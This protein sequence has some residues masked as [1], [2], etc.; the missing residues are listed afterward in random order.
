MGEGVTAYL[1]AVL[2]PETF[3]FCK[4][5]SF[6]S[7]LLSWKVIQTLVIAFLL[8]AGWVVAFRRRGAVFF[9]MSVF[10]IGLIPYSQIVHFYP[11]WAEHYLYIPS[12]GLAMLL[13][14]L[15]AGLP[16][17]LPA[18]VLVALMAG[19]LAFFGFLC[20]RTWQRN[21]LYRDTVG[22][23]KRL[24]QSDS[25]YAYYGYQNLARLLI[26]NGDWA[27]AVVPLKAALAMEPRS[28]VTNNLMGLY[29]LQ[30]K[31]SREAVAYFENAYRAS[32]DLK[33]LTNAG[34][35]FIRMKAYAEAIEIF[36]S[37]Q[38][39]APQQ[40][41]VYTNLI[42]ACELS[43]DAEKAR[44]WGEAGF[45]ALREKDKEAV[46]LLMALA[47]LSYRQGWAEL[48]REK[49]GLILNRYPDSFWYG[50]LARL[51]A[52]K[53]TPDDFLEKVRINYP[54]FESAGKVSVMAAYVIGGEAALA[55][56][57]YEANK[58]VLEEQA[59]G[60]PLIDQE[61]RKAR[62]FISGKAAI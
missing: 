14:S 15:I 58:R 30:M 3:K 43:G 45:Q 39:S 40:L 4:S 1:Q 12:M 13:G 49:V 53:M 35:A 25:P 19:Y 62:E 11:E 2:F 44:R 52:G 27:Q 34:A 55:A 60:H 7:S 51:W 10:L 26:E 31:R 20:V 16:K 8:A 56:P 50:D 54:G 37:I 41:S 33:Y 59:A 6:A 47:R 24:A 9:G 48:L 61:I 22:Y 21:A 32:G 18:Q 42:A 28:D 5:L 57:F 46:V 23:Y 38:R 29:N 17:K 36:E